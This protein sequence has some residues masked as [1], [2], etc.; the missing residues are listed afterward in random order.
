MK[1]EKSKPKQFVTD[2]SIPVKPIYYGQ[3][4]KSNDEESGKYPFTRGIKLLTSLKIF[5]PYLDF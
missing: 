5:Y 2:S 3:T 1:K 4:K